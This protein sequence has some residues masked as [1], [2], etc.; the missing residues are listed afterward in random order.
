[1]HLWAFLCVVVLNAF[2]YL[3]ILDKIYILKYIHWRLGTKNTSVGWQSYRVM[4]SMVTGF[5]R[6]FLFMA[7]PVDSFFEHLLS[8]GIYFQG[9]NYVAHNHGLW[10]PGRM[11]GIKAMAAAVKLGEFLQIDNFWDVYM[12]R[13]RNV[14]NFF[15]LVT[16]CC[17]MLDPI[18]IPSYFHL[19]VNGHCII[20]KNVKLSIAN[21]LRRTE[22]RSIATHNGEKF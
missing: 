4:M 6:A 13:P 2:S 3:D 22:P 20:I 15:I 7:V 11:R 12:G 18:F 9:K 5:D 19:L 17:R 8:L 21:M 10:K 1:M 14:A 16:F